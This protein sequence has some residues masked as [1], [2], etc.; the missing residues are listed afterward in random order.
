MKK[1]L[2]I[3]LSVIFTL[4]GA[5]SAQESEKPVYAICVSKSTIE[6]P[7][8]KEATT[9]LVQKHSEKFN[10]QVLGWG[11]SPLACLEG[12]K[13]I[14]P[15]YVCFLAKHEEANQIFVQ[16][17]HI[18]TR[19]IDDDPYTD[20]IWAILTGY[21]V[22]DVKRII[23]APDMKVDTCCA[24]FGLNLNQFK[25]GVWYSEGTKNH[26]GI[27]EAD[28]V[29]Q[30]R[31][32]GPDDTT[33]AI[34]D[35]YGKNQLF[36]TSGHASP[37][38]WQIGYSYKNGYFFSKDGQLYGRTKDKEEFPIT[39]T[40]SKVY[41]AVG[42]CLI[43]NIADKDTMALAHIHSGG[44]NMMAGYVQPTFFGYMG[45]GIRDYYVG[46]PGRF[47]AA[48]A[49][50]ANN[51]AITWHLNRVF[52]EYLNAYANAQSFI[53]WKNPMLWNDSTMKQMKLEQ[54][55]AVQI[56]PG[57]PEDEIQKLLTKLFSQEFILG[58]SFDLNM[59]AL[60]GDPAWQNPMQSHNKSW[61]QK[62]TSKKLDN[63]KTEWTLTIIPLKGEESF[64][65]V[66]KEEPTKNGRPI[67]Q[68]LPK[69]IKNVVIDENCKDLHA[70][71]TENFILL[72]KTDAM[73]SGKEIVLK[74]TAE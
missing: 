41:L 63:G 26:Y 68:F 65:S 57:L 2:F 21:D 18:I 45:W 31:K 1:V 43:G 25:S 16:M 73:S 29:Y 30:E 39:H 13:K 74:F 27:K 35:A 4:C 23:A 15:T 67:F 14:Q 37:R 66:C 47:T 59:V 10:V 70:T 28:D 42:N 53:G 20:A 44:V 71:I 32:D 48:E 8:W 7:E 69:R 40:N 50:F 49:F 24:G 64:N 33:H 6:D 55:D 58:M 3:A 11:G 51:Q 62:L 56:L 5:V 36:M 46:Q 9:L 19:R 12:L 60:Y 34:A 38:D 61:K 17:C 22:N 54:K 52:P 72:P